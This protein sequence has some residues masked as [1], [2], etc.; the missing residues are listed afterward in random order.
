MTQV[1]PQN[2]QIDS[3]NQSLAVTSSRDGAVLTVQ[4]SRPDVRNAVDYPTA[5]ALAD[6][7]LAFEADD[8]LSAAVFAGSHGTFCAGADLK[9]TAEGSDRANRL[10]RPPEGLEANRLDADGPMGLQGWFSLNR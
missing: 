9:A 10:R 5:R 1:T 7:F 4:L 8:E 2:Q 6:A 3:Q